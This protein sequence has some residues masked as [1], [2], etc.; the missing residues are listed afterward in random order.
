MPRAI[1]RAVFVIGGEDFVT[2]FETHTFGDHVNG[3]SRIGEVDDLVGIRAHVGC[4]FGSR[5]RQQA[6]RASS[7]KFNRL[8]FQFTLPS[9]TVFKDRFRRRAE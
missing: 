8:S 3:V 9:L 5:F 4:K 7:E 6:R 2:R 1:H